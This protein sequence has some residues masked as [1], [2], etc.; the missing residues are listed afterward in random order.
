MRMASTIADHPVLGRSFD[1]R[2]GYACSI[3]TRTVVLWAVGLRIDTESLWR[4]V[5]VHGVDNRAQALP[6]QAGPGPPGCPE[7]WYEQRIVASPPVAPAPPPTTAADPGRRRRRRDTPK[8][9]EEE[10]QGHGHHRPRQQPQQRVA[11]APPNPGDPVV[12]M[13]CTSTHQRGNLPKRLFGVPFRSVLSMDIE[14]GGGMPNLKISD[15]NTIQPGVCVCDASPNPQHPSC[16]RPCASRPRDARLGGNGQ[17]DL[18]FFRGKKKHG[19]SPS[20]TQNMDMLAH[21]L[22]FLVTRYRDRGFTVVSGNGGTSSQ[23][24]PAFVG[25]IVLANVHFKLGWRVDRG[26]LRDVTNNEYATAKKT[27]FVASYEPL[28]NDVSVSIKVWAHGGVWRG[29]EKKLL[30]R[31]W[32]QQKH[33][34]DDPLPNDGA[35]YPLWSMATGGCTG[36]SGGGWIF[37]FMFFRFQFQSGQPAPGQR[38]TVRYQDVMRMVPHAAIKRRPRCHTFRPEATPTKPNEWCILFLFV[39]VCVCVPPH[40]RLRHRLGG[41]G[42]SLADLH[43]HH[44]QGLSR[45]H[46]P[47]SCTG[48]RGR[49]PLPAHPGAVWGWVGRPRVGRRTPC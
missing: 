18:L 31:V 49:I 11:A 32:S 15:R 24:P 20:G 3:Y 14:C 2:D 9:V 46:G 23:P 1:A 6:A 38:T 40:L 19:R 33:F 4:N 48:D 7:V 37:F 21:I 12:R 42:G 36:A 43:A 39:C 28:V 8:R 27:A 30:F 44:L 45:I 16:T 47:R 35:V 10:E 13:I 25:D 41:A 5:V 22:R 34:E 17:A 26:R 29:T